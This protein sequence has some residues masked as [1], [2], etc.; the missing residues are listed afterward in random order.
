MAQE[1]YFCA[2]NLFFSKKNTFFASCKALGTG[3]KHT[4]PLILKTTF[5]I[6]HVH[7]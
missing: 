5:Q 4:L 7:T 3:H 1:F 6:Y 2:I